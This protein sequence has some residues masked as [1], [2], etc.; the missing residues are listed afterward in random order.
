MQPSVHVEG[1]YHLETKR[2]L[3][4]M[5]KATVN[6]GTQQL[7]FQQEIAEAGAVY[8]DVCSADI[9][10]SCGI[11]S[12]AICNLILLVFLLLVVQQLIVILCHSVY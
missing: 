3:R 7:R 9:S 8:R 4:G 11:S 10:P 12:S 1:K 2:T 5:L 6:N